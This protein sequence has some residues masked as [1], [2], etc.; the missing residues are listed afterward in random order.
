MKDFLTIKAEEHRK[1]YSKYWP[2]TAYR[3]NPAHHMFVVYEPRKVFY[4]FT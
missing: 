3:P 1:L 2:I 4:V